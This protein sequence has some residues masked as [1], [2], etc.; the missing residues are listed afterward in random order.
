MAS[1]KLATTLTTLLLLTPTALAQEAPATRP[2]D[3]EIDAAKIEADVRWL[4]DDERD[5]RG[6]GTDG[7]D[8]AAN[9]I[10]DRFE[11]IGLEPVPGLDGYFHEFDLPFGSD[12]DQDKTRLSV[13]DAPP[14]R[15]GV[16]F[17]PFAWSN[18]GDFAGE[19]VFG[20]YS[21]T[22]ER[23]DYDDYADLDARG[24]IVLALRYEPHDENGG[25]RFTGGERS[26]REAALTA[27]ARDAE[28]AGA[29]ALLIVNPPHHRGE[30]DTLEDFGGGPGG[31]RRGVGIPVFQVS[32]QA[33]DAL[34]SAAG[35]ADLATLQDKIDETGKP[36]SAEGDGAEVSGDFAAAERTVKLKNVAGV[37][38]GKN[39]DE[40]VVV[41]GHYDHVGSGEYGSTYGR[42]VHNGAD[43]NA[44]GTAVVLALA[45]ALAERGERPERSIVFVGFTAE[46]VGLIGSE[47]FAEVAALPAEKVAAMVN[48]D[49]VGR[50][51]DEVLFAGGLATAPAIRPIV[52]SADEA[53]PLQVKDLGGGFDGRSDHASYIDLGVP[54]V[55]LFSGLHEQYHA[56][57]DDAD[58]INFAGMA[59][60]AELALD[61]TDA[62]VKTPRDELK[63]SRPATRGGRRVLG[64]QVGGTVNGVFVS[65][66]AQGTLADRAGVRGGDIVVQIGEDLVAD[67]RDIAAALTKLTPGQETIIVVFRDGEQVTLRGTP[68]GE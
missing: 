28:A 66:V 43:D 6:I 40:Y 45:E 34:L 14:L 44:S 16:E 54:A 5:G 17:V 68:E 2:A 21:I 64:V 9:Y 61:V 27:K 20:G 60:V 12:L 19:L 50:V 32:R 31:G 10:A 39:E 24:K 7:L 57:G 1:V 15:A 13:A 56:P 25:S 18:Q 65:D 62:L 23:Y 30:A 52:E 42:E 37:L 63:M 26:S 58:L 55:F 8:E 35:L 38:R 22:S 49:M 67:P 3:G 36:A 59:E 29:A 48:L 51:R 46:E 4:S 11:Q 47:R 53:S 33:A 41:G